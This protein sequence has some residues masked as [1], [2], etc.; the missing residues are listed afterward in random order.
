[1]EYES[2]SGSLSL[3][4]PS[5][6]RIGLGPAPTTSRRASGLELTTGWMTGGAS[7]RVKATARLLHFW[8]KIVIIK[9]FATP[10][11]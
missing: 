9:K 7:N 6:S 3:S 5:R 2:A 1:M 4:R 8:R 10:D 11:V